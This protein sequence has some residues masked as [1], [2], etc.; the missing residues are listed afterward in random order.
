M[1]TQFDFA[2]QEV[3]IAAMA[4]AETAETGCS[5]EEAIERIDQR[6]YLLVNTRCVHCG[7]KKF[8]HTLT[9]TG[10]SMCIDRA[11]EYQPS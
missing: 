4:L 11:S 7:C 2:D 6:L 9:N 1:D 10:R 8:Y 3:R 5:D